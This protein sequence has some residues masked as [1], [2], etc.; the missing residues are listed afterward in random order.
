MST[1]I[2]KSKAYPAIIKATAEQDRITISLSDGREVSIPTAWF[3]RLSGASL[4]DLQNI[5]VS[6]SGYGLHWEA[7]DEDISIKAFLD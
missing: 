3:P 1:A 4:K 6:P 2:R 7:L 5:E